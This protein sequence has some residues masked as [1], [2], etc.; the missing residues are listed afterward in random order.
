MT[1]TDVKVRKTEKEES[2][3]KAVA[4]V[5]IEN[6]IAIHDIRIIDGDK[7]LFIAFP[8]R[9]TAEG[10]FKDIVHPINTPT[11]EEI[12]KLVLDAYNNLD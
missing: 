1:I 9:K 4:S 6:C 8:S 5:T 12:S 2:K 7:G 3:L 10:T 11:R